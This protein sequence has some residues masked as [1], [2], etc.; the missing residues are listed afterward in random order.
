MK[1]VLRNFLLVILCSPLLANAQILDSKYI[2]D[3][4]EEVDSFRNW[5]SIGWQA[6]DTQSLLVDFV[7][8]RSYLLILRHNIPG[9][10]LTNEIEITSNNNQEVIAGIDRVMSRAQPTLNSVIEKI[11][12]LPDRDARQLVRNRLIGNAL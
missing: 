6:L 9:F 3:E 2:F 5:N 1:C 11:Y 7:G 10:R 8:S 4:L 12:V